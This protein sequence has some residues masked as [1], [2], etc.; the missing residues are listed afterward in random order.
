LFS[1]FI[2]I[3]PFSIVYSSFL[4]LI[5][6]LYNIFFVNTI[7]YVYLFFYCAKYNCNENRRCLLC[8]IEIIEITTTTEITTKTIIITTIITITTTIDSF[9]LVLILDFKK[10]ILHLFVK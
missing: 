9:L 10:T 5:K 3:I 4:L 2:L 7:F 6:T 1:N 8:L